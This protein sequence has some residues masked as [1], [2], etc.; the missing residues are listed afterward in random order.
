MRITPSAGSARSRG[1][2]LRA[3]W[4]AAPCPGGRR[5]GAAGAPISPAAMTS[6]QV[7]PAAAEPPACRPA[8]RSAASRR[9]APRARDWPGPPPPRASPTASRAGPRRRVRR[10]GPRRRSARAERPDALRPRLR[11]LRSREDDTIRRAPIWGLRLPS[12]R[13]PYSRPDPGRGCPWISGGGRSI[14]ARGGMSRAAKGADCKSA[15]V[16]LRRFE[17]CFP[18]H[19]HRAGPRIESEEISGARV[20]GYSTMVVQQPSKLRMRV[21][22]PLPAPIPR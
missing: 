10:C 22:F 21:R 6:G 9:K 16:R 11:S 5:R 19:A 7:A 1:R 12:W 2:R 18:H 14:D 13:A 4:R 20:G 17:S 8:P 3:A 15:G